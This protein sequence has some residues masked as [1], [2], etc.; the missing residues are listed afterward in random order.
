MQ[1][2][3]YLQPDLDSM[4]KRYRIQ[5]INSLSGF[6]SVN[7]LGTKDSHSGHNLSVVSS[8]IHLGANPAL[9]GVIFRPATVPRHSYANIRE[10]GCFTFNHIRGDFFKRA[11]LA[12]AKY[13]PE[14]SE[15]EK[16]GLTPLFE[17]DFPAPFVKESWLRIG[18]NY[19]EEYKIRAND[20]ILLVGEILRVTF[21][22]EAME[23]DGFL[24]LAKAG[25][26]T[27]G[28]LDRYYITRLIDKMPYAKP[29]EEGRFIP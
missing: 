28:G 25:S 8:V 3:T 23:E 26:L 11:H 20:T 7:L 29:G 6:K 14:V 5:F 19:I 15:F 9:M 18:L 24:D 16:T 27:L 2:R 1:L 22:E 17:K 21:P 4:P 13:P 10:H 12:S